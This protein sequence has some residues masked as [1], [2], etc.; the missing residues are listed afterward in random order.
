MKEKKKLKEM[1][2][3]G[4]EKVSMIQEDMKAY[5]FNTNYNN[6]FFSDHYDEF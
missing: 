3:K 1:K 5:I 6:D 4:F 2:D